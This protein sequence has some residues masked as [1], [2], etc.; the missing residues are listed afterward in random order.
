[1]HCHVAG[2]ALT[3]THG[4]G[5]VDALT[6]RQVCDDLNTRKSGG[7]VGLAVARG[8]CR[9][10]YRWSSGSRLVAGVRY[11]QLPG[12]LGSPD[13]RVLEVMCCVLLSMLEAV[14]G[15]FRLLELVGSARGDALCA[16]L[17]C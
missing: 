3:G 1:V 13:S 14:E 8:R 9:A 15:G 17:Y 10:R 16:V 11:G 4:S 6:A 12:L 7:S 2:G 5:S